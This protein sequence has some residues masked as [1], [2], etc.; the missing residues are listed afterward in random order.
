MIFLIFRKKVEVIIHESPIPYK[1]QLLYWLEILKWHL[2][3]KITFHTKK[4]VDIFE[5]SY[6]KLPS[7]KYILQEHSKYFCKFRDLSREDARLELNLP[8]KKLIFLCIGFIQPHKGFDIAIKSFCKNSS[9]MDLYIV[10]SLRIKFEPYAEYLQNLRNISREA[11]NIHIVESYLSDEDF[12]TWL[13]ASDVVV[14]PYREIWSSGVVARAKLFNK[15]VIVSHV[16][17]LSEQIAENDIIYEN[18]DELKSIFRS[19]EHEKYREDI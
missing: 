4:E 9:K 8:L 2:C 7:D 5:S 6:F 3:S 10:G 18:E 15:S 17:G 14:A 11:N 1:N 16:G 19:F 12:D 13:I